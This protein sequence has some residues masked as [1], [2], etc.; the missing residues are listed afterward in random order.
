MISRKNVRVVHPPGG[1]DR[2]GSD[3]RPD[4]QE[5]SADWAKLLTRTFAYDSGKP[6]GLFAALHYLRCAHD[7]VIDFSGPSLRVANP[8]DNEY[9]RI[10]EQ[11][12][13]PRVTL[14]RNLLAELTP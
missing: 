9:Q 13:L 11:V 7:C 1:S 12:L 6:D 3:P 5:D 4:L 8:Q 2:W 14:I 10:R